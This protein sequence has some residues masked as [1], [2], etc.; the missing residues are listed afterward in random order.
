MA[1]DMRPI[2]GTLVLLGVL[3]AALMVFQP[4]TADWPGSGYTE[5]ARRY[6]KA[7]LRRDSVSLMELSTSDAPVRWSLAAARR[8]PDTLALWARRVEAWAGEH[9]GDTTEVFVYA[10]GEGCDGKPIVLRVVGSGSTM[11]VVEASSACLNP[12]QD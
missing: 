4:Y 8:H 5:P 12:G 11:K 7:A 1:T 3:L 10:P 9:R 2:Y 6:I